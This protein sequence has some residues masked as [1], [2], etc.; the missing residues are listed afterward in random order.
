MREPVSRTPWKIAA[1]YSSRPPSARYPL[2]WNPVSRRP[3]VAVG[4]AKTVDV[5]LMS[6]VKKLRVDWS[7]L[8]LSG[9]RNSPPSIMNASASFHSK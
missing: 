9:T 2:A 5:G 1:R 3:L 4:V 6:R 8:R 7:P